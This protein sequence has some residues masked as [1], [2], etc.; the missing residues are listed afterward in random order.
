[1]AHRRKPL[2]LALALNTAVIG[3]EVAGGLKSNS[4]S[5]LVD[6][7]HNVSDE[8]ALLMLV[9]AYSLRT[10]VSRRFLLSA[11]LFNS[12]GLATISAFMILQAL[13]RLSHP[14]PLLGVFTV[15]AGLLGVIGNLLVAKALSASSVEAAAIRLAYFHN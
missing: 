12:L 5:L 8:A 6:G 4:L 7:I 3:A 2:A 15:G 14:V 11:N 9:F 1:M 13:E 10:G